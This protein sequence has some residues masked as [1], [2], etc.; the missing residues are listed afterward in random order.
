MSARGDLGTLE[1]GGLIEIAALQPEL[2]YLFRHALVQDAAYASLLKQDRRALHRAAAETILALHPDRQ[3]AL[4]GVIGLHF[5]QAGDADRA[6]QQYVVAGEHALERFANKEATGFFRRAIALAPESNTQLR[7]HAA[8]GGAKAGWT[9]ADSDNEINTLEAVLTNTDTA[10]QRMV[11]EAY[12]WLA[13]L[14]RQRG[15]VPDTSPDLKR[16][17]DRGLEIGLQLKDPTAAALPRALMGSYLSFMGK[18]HEGEVEMNEALDVIATKGDV[19]SV[20]MISDFL[21]MTQARLGEFEAAFATIERA[22]ALAGDGDDIARVDVDIALSSLHLEQ[23]EP[24][25]AR[26]TAYECAV[27]AEGLGAYA[28]VVVSN[29]MYGAAS[30]ARDDASSA[31]A[32]LE[33]GEELVRLTGMAPMRTLL[34]AFLGSTRAMLGDMPGGIASWDKALES[35]RG[36]SDR[37]GEAQTLWGRG[38]TRAIQPNSDLPVAIA[39]LDAAVTLFEEMDAQPA[40][41]RALLDR[42]RALRAAGKDDAGAR[43]ESRALDL[44]RKLGLRDA[45]FA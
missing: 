44:G 32:P 37:Y 8:I 1:A 36:M 5:E 45:P 18:L 6:A 40:L 26:T 19:V 15:E 17:M 30:L 29:L 27:R 14:R 13:L 31:K 25:L 20:A 43:D 2:E 10:D 41:A 24:E 34:T 35:A 39:D 21:A 33:R 42:A 12:F 16:A 28:C 3:Q 7:L 38:R 11:A 4:A 23:G 22:K 9:F